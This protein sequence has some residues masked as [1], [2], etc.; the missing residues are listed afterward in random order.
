M[1]NLTGTKTETNLREA[2]AGESMA[3]N[4]YTIFASRARKEGLEVIA[5]IF[6]ETAHNEKEHGEMWLKHLNA[7]NDTRYNLN[8]GIEGEGYEWKEMYPRM[9][10]EA[11]EEGFIGIAEEFEKVAEIEKS[12]Y[13]KYQQVL[14]QL[15]N[16]TLFKAE[17][18]VAWRCS[19]CG[20]IHLGTDAPTVC[21]VCKHTQGYFTKLP[22]N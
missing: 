15:E 14:S 3:R 13:N 6:D 10:A 12:H 7:V 20:Y 9:A 2:F 19:N 5:K 11:R 18:S 4:K 21:P 16:G 1:K 22:E 17:N 8:S